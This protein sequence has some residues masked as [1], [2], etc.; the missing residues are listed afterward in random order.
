MAGCSHTCQHSD[1]NNDN[2]IN[3]FNS[4]AILAQAMFDSSQLPWV[5]H[6]TDCQLV[7]VRCL[8]A[9]VAQSW[10]ARKWNAGCAPRPSANHR[11]PVML[12]SFKSLL[13]RQTQRWTAEN[14]SA[15]S[16]RRKIR[17]CPW[18]ERSS[19]VIESANC[20]HYSQFHRQ[21]QCRKYRQIK[22][23]LHQQTQCR[24]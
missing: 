23:Q 11:H 16:V 6:M 7:K 8:V 12:I 22:S 21:A 1:G 9:R 19:G 13:H 17:L 14:V 4:V 24:S 18:S 2:N 5:T 3:K 20:R 10:L 15:R